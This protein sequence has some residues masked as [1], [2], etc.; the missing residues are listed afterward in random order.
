MVVKKNYTT[1]RH[2]PVKLTD[3]ELQD[4]SKNT[5]KLIQNLQETIDE[6]KA[7]AADYTTKINN[8]KSSIDIASK[9]VLSGEEDRTIECKVQL[10]TDNMRKI[11]IRLDTGIVVDE[12]NL[13]NEDLQQEL[14]FAKG[15][16]E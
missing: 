10:N 12:E 7:V 11:V 5:A 4:I 9:K 8:I 16:E 1:K 3:L 15:Q 13:T 14:D 2:L 6:K